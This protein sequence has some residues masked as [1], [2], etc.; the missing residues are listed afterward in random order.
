MSQRAPR[1]VIAGL[2]G[3]AGKTLVSVGLLL[4]ARA[5]SLPV[6]AFKKGPDYID[7]LWLS[8]ASGRPARNLDTCLMGTD[9]ALAA[10][11]EHRV[12]DGL[13]VV[14]G[15]RGLLDGVDA[16]GTH[17]TAALARGLDAPILLVADATKVTR[18]VAA[19]VRGCQILEPDSAIA[20]VILNR[21]AGPRHVR[22]CREA[23]ESICGV[24]VLG[25]VA[26][27]GD[28][29]P[30][31]GRHLGLVPPEEC[32]RTGAR[33]AEVTRM[34]HDQVDMDALLRIAAAARPLPSRHDTGLARSLSQPGSTPLPCGAAD[35]R[36][37][38][39]GVVRDAAFSFYYPENLEAL[40]AAG[41]RLVFVSALTGTE[42]PPGLHALYIGG[43]FP[44]THAPL[45]A[46][47]AGFLASL[48]GAAHS[49]LPIFAECG[50]LML[51]ASAIRWRGS[52]APMAGVLPFEVEVHDRPRG[53]GYARLRV[54]RP[55]AFFPEDTV[56]DGHQFHY[57]W[58]VG[59]DGTAEAACAVERGTGAFDGRDAVT[60]GRVW[61]SYT[62]LHARA[63]PAW[64]DAMVRA[65]RSRKVQ[66]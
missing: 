3:D 62:H 54:D 26:R 14:E 19:A 36:G 31:P 45:I 35:G 27:A 12:E 22:I 17:S 28:S 5:R 66:A 39:I 24:P 55:N 20:G 8:W 49:G 38:S 61:A 1:V 59:W 57:S 48:R 23:I 41:S 52:R 33:A 64:T 7:A 4:A 16:A 63:T 30:L 2:S 9:G 13:N 15:N 32:D 6:A 18:T 60:V 65:A 44:E 56:L 21:V 53:H 11:A 34:I 42:L 46:A 47:N 58:P 43:G 29:G 10:F 50:G 37:L 25:A 40:E 51:L